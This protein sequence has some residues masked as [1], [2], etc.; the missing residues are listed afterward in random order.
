MRCGLWAL[1]L[2]Y[3]LFGK[4]N[5]VADLTPSIINYMGWGMDVAES[6]DSDVSFYIVLH[7]GA[8][9]CEAESSQHVVF[10]KHGCSLN[11]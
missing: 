1:L 11:K 4:T 9:A 7:S 3:V 10:C 8:T 5:L 6:W 2:G